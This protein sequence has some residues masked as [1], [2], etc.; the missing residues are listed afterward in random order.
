MPSLFDTLHK[1]TPNPLDNIEEILNMNDWSFSRISD[2]ELTVTLT[3]KYCDYN[4]IFLWQPDMKGIQ[5]NILYGLALSVSNEYE[6]AKTLMKMN[7]NTWLG[8]F[9]ISSDTSIPSYRYTALIDSQNKHSYQQLENIIDIALAQ[10]EGNYAAFS[11]LSDDNITDD[12]T[13]PLALMETKGT[14]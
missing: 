7:E 3:G 14:S 8:H 5:I 11:L 1:E 9:E 2:N 4:L 12:K 6:A 13:L 10:C